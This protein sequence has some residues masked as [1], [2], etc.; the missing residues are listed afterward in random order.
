MNNSYDGLF[1]MS[2]TRYNVP[3]AWLKAIAIT[4]SSLNP[5]AMRPEP[6][7]GDASYGL[8]QILM[9]TAKGLG[10]QGS[11]MDLYN[12][13]TNIDLG[14][15]LIAENIHRFGMDF[16]AVYSAYNSGSSVSYKTNPQVKA[17][18]A[19]AVSNLNLVL[20]DIQNTQA[21]YDQM[22]AEISIGDVQPPDSQDS[23][24]Q[25]IDNAVSEMSDEV[26]SGGVVT[27]AIGGAIIA[28]LVAYFL[29]K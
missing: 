8:M 17:N 26:S 27:L 28:G 29:T 1:D 13:S 12:P 7:I 25:V 16:Q 14:A 24:G 18:V 22:N 3:F 10:F 15:K 6:Q 23:F 21:A 9:R 20:L 5:N 4:E 2:A 19:R 11:E